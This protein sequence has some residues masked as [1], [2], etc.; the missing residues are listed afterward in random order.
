M[1]INVQ[2]GCGLCAPPEWINFDASPTL[3]LQ[4][5]PLFGKLVTKVDFPAAVRYGDIIKG[6]PGIATGS[7]DAVY[8]SHVLEHLSLQDFRL[9]LTRTFS[10]LKPGGVFRCVVPDLESS[11]ETYFSMRGEHNPLASLDLMRATL[12]GYEQRP[13][14][15]KQKLMTLFGNSHHLWMWDQYSLR[16]ELERTGFSKV[17]KASFNDSKNQDFQHVEEEGRFSNAICFEAI[18]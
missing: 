11:V 16:S 17:R 1:A 18:K 6:L 7:C 9:A 15:L 14:G 4:R 12:L 2:F 10:M 5:I 8:C 3:R 13:Q